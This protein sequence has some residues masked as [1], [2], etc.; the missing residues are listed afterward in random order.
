MIIHTTPH[1][2]SGRILYD[3]LFAIVL[4]LMVSMSAN[5]AP[6]Y[7]VDAHSQI[8]QFVDLSL[9]QQKMLDNNVRLTILS[10]RGPNAKPW[11]I[12]P[13]T[14]S[15]IVDAIR[16]KSNPYNNE[17]PGDVE[18]YIS[19]FD[20]QAVEYGEYFNAV[21]EL[22][23]YH[24]AKSSTIPEVVVDLNGPKVGHAI[25]YSLNNNIP[26][27]LHIEF[28]ALPPEL[29]EVYFH[30]LE[31][32]LDEYPDHPFV[33]IHMG[34][35]GIGDVMR[36]IM[37]HENIY[38]MTSHADPI[39]AETGQPWTNLFKGSTLA[40]QWR[41]AF[42]HFPTRFIFAIDNVFSIHWTRDYDERMKYWRDAMES[43]PD[44]VAN[45][46]AYGNAERL[47]NLA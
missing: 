10:T 4:C 43:L 38:F 20:K 32:K 5:A 41:N 26:V 34:Q 27:I 46:I 33:L 12:A 42:M 19:F 31:T 22:L 29:K 39:S 7:F 35:L 1:N 11:D 3:H 28:A 13:Y 17:Y 9:V 8:D 24:A 30:E 47:W 18:E 6:D 25:Q 36:L 23:I 14:G 37:R 15:N 16:S 2:F 45:L 44:D 21:A 40:P